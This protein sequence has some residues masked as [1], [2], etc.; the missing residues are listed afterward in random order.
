MRILR[1]HIPLKELSRLSD[2]IF[3]ILFFTK[4]LDRKIKAFFLWLKNGGVNEKAGD[5]SCVGLCR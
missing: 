5:N 3:L 1:G 2:F 4:C